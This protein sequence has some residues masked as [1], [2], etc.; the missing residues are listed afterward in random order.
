[1]QSLSDIIDE[2]DTLKSVAILARRIVADVFLHLPERLLAGVLPGYRVVARMRPFDFILSIGRSGL[3]RRLAAS[4]GRGMRRH[5][6]KDAP[7]AW[8]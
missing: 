2:L 1:M 7:M 3:G 4:T 5:A 8:R 6:T